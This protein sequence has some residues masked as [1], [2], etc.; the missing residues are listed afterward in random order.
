MG[1]ILIGKTA[2]DF[3]GAIAD[4]DAV[5]TARL[6]GRYVKWDGVIAEPYKVRGGKRLLTATMGGMTVVC[7]FEAA[8]KK[9]PAKGDRIRVEG[10][11]SGILRTADPVHVDLSDC[12]LLACP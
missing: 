2:E 1:P 3:R 4:L 8:P 12:G 9:R 6:A 10:Y 5:A 7:R 11:I